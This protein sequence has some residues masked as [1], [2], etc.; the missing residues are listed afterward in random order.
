MVKVPRSKGCRVCVQR[1][2]K[3]D[4]TRPS[5]Q[6]CIRSNRQCTGFDQLKFIDE[7]PALRGAHADTQAAAQPQ[8]PSSTS[9]SS[10]E[11]YRPDVAPRNVTLPFQIMQGPLSPIQSNK[12]YQGAFERAALVSLLAPTVHQD[13]LLAQFIASVQQPFSPPTIRSHSLWLAEVARRPAHSNALNWAIRAIS[14]SHLARKTGDDILME[15]SHR[16]YGR[17]LLKLNDALQDEKE[18]FSSDTLSA[19]LLLSFYEIFNCTDRESWIR[20]AGGAGRLIQLRGPDRHRTGFGRLVFAACRNSL[21]MDA[22]HRRAEC[23]LAEPAWRHLC[24][25]I[26]GE[27]RLSGLLGNNTYEEYFQEIVTYPAYLGRASSI[28][29]DSD[30]TIKKLQDVRAEGLAHRSRFRS[31]HSQMDEELAETGFKPIKVASSYNDQIFPFVYDF[32]DIHV[33]SLYCCYWAIMCAI[34]ISVVALET[35]IA[36]L[37]GSQSPPQRTHQLDSSEKLGNEAV[38]GQDPEHS[39]LWGTAKKMGNMHEYIS[40][41]AMNA[42]EICRS[43]EYMCHTPFLGPLYLLFGMRLALKMPI[44]IVEKAWILGKLQDIGQD[45]GLAAVEIATYRTKQA[46]GSLIEWEQSSSA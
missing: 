19:T 9:H 17:A 31:I 20:H 18:A 45:I 3:C 41:N 27:L 26:D 12:W 8:S 30:I 21:I 4:Q 6:R 44:K 38:Q 40:E 32:F 1:R 11:P 16:I 46:A 2:I 23:F 13:Q 39:I 24:W 14:I 28:I 36:S 35:K 29:G 33:A 34:N 43:V 10:Q 22:F 25:D 15:S 42:R 7:G 37:S 5:C